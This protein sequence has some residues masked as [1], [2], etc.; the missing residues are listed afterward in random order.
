MSASFSV[1]NI[2]LIT[3]QFH[4]NVLEIKSL[5]LREIL[6]YTCQIII[7]VIQNSL[8][9]VNFILMKVSSL[10]NA[11]SSIQCLTNLLCS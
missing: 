5:R 1:I 4:L 9:S 7:W 11:V 10:C 2:S 8:S 6:T 3:Q